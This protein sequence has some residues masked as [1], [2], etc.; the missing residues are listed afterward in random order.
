M[1][2][3]L[4]FIGE[5]IETDYKSGCCTRYNIPD[6]DEWI[7]LKPERVYPASRLRYGKP[8]DGEIAFYPTEGWFE[9]I[10]HDGSCRIL[11]LDPIPAPEPVSEWD[12]WVDEMPQVG[13]DYIAHVDYEDKMRAWFKRMPKRD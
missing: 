12:K 2:E 11:I 7:W 4:F 6:S 13:I 8:K 10:Q 1:S 5:V 3:K 9:L